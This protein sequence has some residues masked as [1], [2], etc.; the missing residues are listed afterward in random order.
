MMNCE[1]AIFN[2]H[3]LPFPNEE[4]DIDE[5]L[6]QFIDCFN[7]LRVMGVRTILLHED[8][9][10]L[11]NKLVIF[12]NITFAHWLQRQAVRFKQQNNSED[13]EKLNLFRHAISLFNYR[14]D[15]G[16][17]DWPCMGVQLDEKGMRQYVDSPVLM[18]IEWYHTF[19]VSVLSAP[20]WRK[21]QLQV[22]YKW[23][24]IE[25]NSIHDVKEVVYNYS[26]RES[27]ETIKQAILVQSPD[28]KMLIR[29]WKYFFPRIN[30]GEDVNDQLCALA[31]C[32]QYK[33]V[34]QTLCIISNYICR[35]HKPTDLHL[36]RLQQLGINA[37]DESDTT[38]NKYGKT[39]VFSFGELGIKE[40]FKHLKFGDGIRVHYYVDEQAFHVGYIGGH[41]PI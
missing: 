41:L 22:I 15:A 39:R 1:L 28:P 9:G 37:S 12:E 24:N 27:I 3:S 38:K 20:C 17:K 7:R 23:F 2:H 5:A 14:Q 33:A 19:L 29:Y 36:Q 18:A 26:T 10:D 35:S 8:V 30:R 40:C 32:K 4:D 31:Q 25:Q 6:L 13:R 21:T 11:W 16:Y 34:L